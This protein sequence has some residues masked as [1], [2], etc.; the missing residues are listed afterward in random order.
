MRFFINSWHDFRQ[1]LT[2]FFRAMPYFLQY[3]LVIK[4][5]FSLVI[6]PLFFA[7]TNLILQTTVDGFVANSNILKFLIT[8]AGIILTII[9]VT[10]ILLG[11]SLEICGAIII[12]SRHLQ[13]QSRINFHQTFLLSLKLLPKMF[14]LG[15]MILVFYLTIL[16]PIIGN[17]LGLSFLSWL[18]LPN[19]VVDVIF[20]SPFYISVYFLVILI[21]FALSTLWIFVF[22]FLALVKYNILT[23]IKHSQRLVLDNLKFFIKASFG[24]GFYSSI[25]IFGAVILWSILVSFLIHKLNLEAFLPQRLIILLFLTQQLIILLSTI[26]FAPLGIFFITKLFLH[27]YQ[28]PINLDI[29]KLPATIIDAGLKIRFVR[30][31]L[32]ALVIISMIITLSFPLK[33]FIKTPSP[34]MIVS[35]RAGGH[36]A[37]E[38]SLNG[39]Q[40]S[41]DLGIKWAEIDI[42][43]TQ[44]GYYIVHHDRTLKRLTGESHPSQE[45]TLDEI[46]K[47]TMRNSNSTEKIATLNQVF[48]LARGKINLFVELKG[49]T[50][51]QQMVDDV[52]KLAKQY[53]VYDQIVLISGQVKLIHQAKS[54]YPDVKTGMIYYLALGDTRRFSTDYLIIEEMLANREFIKKA[55][56]ANKRVIV[57]TVNNELDAEKYL[58]L[59]VDGIITDKPDKLSYLSQNLSL[60]DLIINAFGF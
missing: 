30:R 8:P 47:L 42:Q 15:T 55:H 13:S 12:S 27:L 52:I 19:F 14:G 53:Q 4:L 16:S 20:S 54:K 32:I 25:I 24:F 34:V 43:R 21:S 6:I 57:W 44:D 38:N 36:L 29:P 49:K 60:Q 17:I 31:P 23:A 51:D 10:L 11:A 59:A 18:K 26:L 28:Q 39:L 7:I 45:L 5:F 33:F 2:D 35:H 40:K 56:H 37:T 58:N 22:H 1:I 9:A 50:A 46:Q 41:I 3:Q 48:E